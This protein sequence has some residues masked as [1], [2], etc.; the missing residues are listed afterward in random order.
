MVLPVPESETVAGEFEA[1]LMIETL[2]VKLPVDPGAKTALKLVLCPAA[3]FRGREG[4]VRLN[5]VPAALA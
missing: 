1:L 3:K 5:P 4:P 2:P